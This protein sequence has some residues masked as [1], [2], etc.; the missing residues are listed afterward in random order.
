MPERM[1][2]AFVIAATDIIRERIIEFQM[3]GA[4]QR[5]EEEI[6]FDM[7]LYRAIKFSLTRPNHI[8]DAQDELKRQVNAVLAPDYVVDNPVTGARGRMRLLEHATPEQKIL[9]DEFGLS[10]KN[11]KCT[12]P[13]LRLSTIS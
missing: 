2:T 6:P 10:E 11:F 1:R 13:G 7:S 3:R 4:G 8:R 5:A 12:E 9:I